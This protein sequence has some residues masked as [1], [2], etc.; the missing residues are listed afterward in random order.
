MVLRY[1]EIFY[2]TARQNE[3]HWYEDVL[4]FARY[5]AM[6]TMIICTNLSEEDRT[7]FVDAH[8]LMPTFKQAYQNNTVVMVK[9]CINDQVEPVYYFLREFL[10]LRETKTLRPYRSSVVSLQV[11]Q[12]DQYIFKKCLTNSIDRMKRNLITG[13]GVN[14]E[15]ISILFSDCVEYNPQDIA[16]FANVI[17]S[18]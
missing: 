8:A 13:D 7:F 15:Q 18:I 3:N 17:G 5:S 10:E 9:D 16:R 6:E 1:G 12:D 2:L 14:S 4:A 11:I